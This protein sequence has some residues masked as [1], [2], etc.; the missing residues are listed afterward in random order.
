MYLYIV[1][2]YGFLEWQVPEMLTYL[3]AVPEALKSYMTEFITD[4]E[5]FLA[6]QEETIAEP[7]ANDDSE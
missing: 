3:P 6:S 2:Q 4:F 5:E 7:A 1:I